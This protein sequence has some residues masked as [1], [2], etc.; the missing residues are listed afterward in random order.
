MIGKDSGAVA[1]RKK[2]SKYHST[3]TQVGEITFDSIKEARRYNELLLMERSGVI[4]DL[5]RQV[6]FILIPAQRM[7]GTIGP[8]GGFKRGKLL[9]RELAYVA[10]FVYM[11]DGQKVVEDVKGYKAGTAYTVFTIKRK[12]MLYVYGIKVE[13]V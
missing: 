8:R 5:E 2:G 9:E 6:R 4:S 10:D 1:G 3:K 11:R 13:E 7:P 12:L